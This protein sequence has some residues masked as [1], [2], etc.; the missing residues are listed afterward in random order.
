MYYQIDKVYN[1][2][3]LI[4]NINT[5]FFKTYNAKKYICKL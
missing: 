3:E 4:Y 5:G 2:C 1:V